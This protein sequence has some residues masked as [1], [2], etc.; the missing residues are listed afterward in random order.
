MTEQETALALWRQRLGAVTLP[1][2]SSADAVEQLLSAAVSLQQIARLLADDPSLALEIVIAA[3][4]LPGAR[5]DVQGMQHALNLLGV[6]RIQAVVR[7]RTTRLLNGES[8]AHRDSLQAIATSRFAASLVSRWEEPRVP[9]SSELL[10]CVTLLLGLARWKLPLAAPQLSRQ[11]EQRVARGERRSRV[12]HELLGCSMDSLNQA[13]LIDAGFPPDSLLLRAIDPDSRVLAQASR[14]A[15]T[16][17]MAPELPPT[18]ARWLRQ[19][20][21]PCLIAHLLAWAAHDGWYEPRTQTLLRVVSARNNTP[22]ARVISTT[23]RTAA[24]VSRRLE[25]H[26]GLIFTPAEQLFWPPRPPRSLHPRLAATAV[27]PA[28]ARLT[29]ADATT[30]SQG[31]VTA[32]TTTPPITPT[33]TPTK[34]PAPTPTSTPTLTAT[35]TAKTDAPAAP[36]KRVAAPPA[37]ADANLR[38]D[39]RRLHA[40][41]HKCRENEFSDLRQLMLEATTALDKG[42]G[43]QRSLVF[44]RPGNS[45]QVRCFVKHGFGDEQSSASLAVPANSDNLFMRLLQQGGTL[46]VDAAT[47]EAATRQLPEML[48]PLVSPSGFALTCIKMND[49]PLGLI[50][51]D[52]GHPRIEVDAAQYDVLR[53]VTGHFN[54]VFARLARKPK[55]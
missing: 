12:E 14:H 4:R 45:E 20:T 16:D 15:W 19:R 49:R 47:A 53:V 31:R 3:A 30:P 55:T 54:D 5:D 17:T 21:S 50:W 37:A 43:L 11:L 13:V 36:G 46:R 6:K 26:A 29:P 27:A 25:R 2:L 10:S 41:I 48:R 7:A 24:H 34:T 39:P 33:A 22:L 44:L 9:G 23:H 38:A 8:V 28:A 40:F 32:P 35:A 51:A 52:S 18:I 42:M 1:L